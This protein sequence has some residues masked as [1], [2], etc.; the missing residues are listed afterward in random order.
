MPKAPRR[1]ARDRRSLSTLSYYALS[2][3][4]NAYRRSKKKGTIALGPRALRIRVRGNG[5]GGV[6][7]TGPRQYTRVRFRRRRLRN[8]RVKRQLFARKRRVRVGTRFLRGN[9]DPYRWAY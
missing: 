2:G 8:T 7:R 9:F 5:R 6:V 3:L 4:Y 1:R